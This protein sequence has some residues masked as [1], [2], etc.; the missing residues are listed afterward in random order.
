[1]EVAVIAQ[2]MPFS[3]SSMNYVGPAFRV[4]SKNKECRQHAKLAKRVEN[5]RRCIGIRPVIECQGNFAFACR[6]VSKYRP[7]HLAIAM[8]RSVY[9]TAGERQADRC[10][11]NHL[12]ALVG[13]RTPI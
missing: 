2:L 1:M 6:K 13:P 7:E 8:K 11:E 3:N 5:A 12:V 10:G 9:D 4:S